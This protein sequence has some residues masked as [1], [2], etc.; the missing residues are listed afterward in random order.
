[1]RKPVRKTGSKDNRI[2]ADPAG[3]A[4]AMCAGTMIC[5]VI[6]GFVC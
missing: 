6:W 1:M 4:L 3:F 5:T 2:I